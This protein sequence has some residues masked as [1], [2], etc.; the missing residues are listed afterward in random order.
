MMRCKISAGIDSMIS[1]V[2]MTVTITKKTCVEML[3]KIIPDDSPNNTSESVF[4]QDEAPAH[5]SKMA[6][7]R[8]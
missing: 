5:T 7:E 3:Q 1:L 2:G 8:L 4:M 6:M